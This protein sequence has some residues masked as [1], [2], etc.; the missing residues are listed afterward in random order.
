MSDSYTPSMPD[1]KYTFLKRMEKYQRLHLSPDQIEKKENQRSIR[2]VIIGNFLEYYDLT[3]FI[4]LTFLLNPIFLPQD[5]PFITTITKV[6]MFCSAYLMRPVGALFWGWIGDRY[7]RVTVLTSTM[8]LMAIAATSITLIPPYQELGWWSA[9]LVIMCR[10]IQGFAAGG[11]FQAATVY[12]AEYSRPPHSFL[13]DGCISSSSEF[14][15]LFAAL[16]ATLCLYI[17]SDAGWKIPFYLGGGLAVLG[18]WARQALNETPEFLKAVQEKSKHEKIQ[19]PKLQKTHNLLELRLI[20]FFLYGFS[21]VLVVFTFGYCPEQL[22]KLGLKHYM[23]TAQSAFISFLFAISDF[24]WGYAAFKSKD[25]FLI[26]KLKAVCLA[27]ALFLVLLVPVPQGFIF[28]TLLQLIGLLESGPI[29]LT[30]LF[31]KSF[32]VL[33]RCRNMMLT[34]SITKAIMYLVPS[35]LI[36]W[37]SEKYGQ[38]AVAWVFFVSSLAYVFGAFRT[39]KLLRPVYDQLIEE[40]ENTTAIPG[41]H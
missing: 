22:A 12:L 39:E 1:T 19:K 23:I 24:T 36:F 5:D 25:P 21:A 41:S 30:P 20:L 2:L 17:F 11:E 27:S 3:L 37:I 14:G 31:I 18:A 16:V 7:G 9:I 28:I 10:F 4:H 6:F 15:R 38:H 29:P 26:F 32:A 13:R 35:Y 40:N 34:W 8:F 33:S